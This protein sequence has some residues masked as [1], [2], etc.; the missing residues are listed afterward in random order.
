MSSH[1][2]QPPESSRDART[3]PRWARLPVLALLLA[4]GA[5]ELTA[6][7]YALES[8]EIPSWL[9]ENPYA[10]W[11][12]TWQMFTYLDRRN[13]LLEAQVQRDGAWEDIDLEAYFPFRWE[14]GPRYARS[15]FRKSA[16]RMRTL[17]QATCHRVSPRP[18]R[19]RFI[20]T[21][22]GKTLGSAEQPK[23]KAKVSGILDWD[24]DDSY[25]LPRGEEL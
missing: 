25:R 10:L 23:D 6:Y 2:R 11:P 8:E 14:S 7:K 5:Y 16:S 20:H 13:N 17:A 24:C 19:V 18:D 15:S 4:L 9:R 22:W 21:A 12:A 3:T 1:E